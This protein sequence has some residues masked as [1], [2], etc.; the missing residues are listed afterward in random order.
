MSRTVLSLLLCCAAAMAQTPAAQITGIVKD[1]AGATVVGAEVKA[2]QT[3]TGV[4]HTATSGT[5]GEYTL[6]DLPPGTYTLEVSKEGFGKFAQNEVVV[7]Q[8]AA[9]TVNVSLQTA[10]SGTA[11][12]LK[13]LGFKPADV[14]GTVKD[15]ARLDRRSHMLQIHQ[16]LGLITL[17][18]LV[19]TL[20]TGSGAKGDRNATASSSAT[21]RE[22]HAALGATTAGLYITTASFAIF[23]P[24]VPGTKTRGPILVHKALAFIHGPGMILT[25]ILGAMAYNQRS[26][27]EKVHG[28]ASA[29]GAVAAITGIAYGAAILSVTIK[30]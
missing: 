2:T 3:A 28:I 14:Q 13:D 5:A 6:P 23:A 15:Q 9:S 8:N 21:G 4:V 30:F 29:H 19:A 27:G 7:R 18:P 16:R 1:A 17:A 11:P 22:L 26:A 24:K 12:S 10:T 25:P 20:V